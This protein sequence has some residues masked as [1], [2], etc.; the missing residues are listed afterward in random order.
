[1]AQM[2]GG[3]GGR[4]R[5]QGEGA[6]KREKVEMGR[7]REGEKG[8]WEKDQG[9]GGDGGRAACGRR[10]RIQGERGGRKRCR[11]GAGAWHEFF[12]IPRPVRRFTALS[13]S[14]LARENKAGLYRTR[15]V[16]SQPR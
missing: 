12:A 4:K 2:G 8:D 16:L 7:E 1:M 11:G 3:E 5:R 10:K 14:V 9:E 15:I 13:E 6:L